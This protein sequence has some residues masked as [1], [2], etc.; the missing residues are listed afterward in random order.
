MCNA[1][2]GSIVYYKFIKLLILSY[3]IVIVY[4][5]YKVVSMSVVSFV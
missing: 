4:I 3:S 1:P 2:I 5:C